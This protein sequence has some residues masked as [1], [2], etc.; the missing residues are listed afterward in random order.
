MMQGSDEWIRARL[1]QVTAS[2][3][4]DVIARTKSG[5]GASRSSYAAQ[6]VAERLTGVPA[7][8]YQS[9][10]MLHGIETEAE[11]RAAYAFYH[12]AEVVQ[13]GYIEHPS[14]TEAGASPDGFVGDDGLVE[15][16]APNTSTH[17]DTLLSKSVPLKYISQMQWQLACTGRQ[18]CDYVSYDPRMP[19]DMRLFVNRIHRDENIIRELEEQVSIFL[20]D[21][22]ATVA[23]LERH[24][25]P[26]RESCPVD[27]PILAAG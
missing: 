7:E 25:R 22:R 27:I 1:G 9:A 14:I 17:I 23:A 15:I 11:A 12:D 3:I 19:A 21:V 8:T 4:A 2:R 20:G 6:L 18:W 16:K 10:A 13:V 24:Y 26:A 5:W